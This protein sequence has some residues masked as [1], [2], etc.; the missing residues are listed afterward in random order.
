MPAVFRPPRF[1]LR[2]FLFALVLFLHETSAK[3]PLLLTDNSSLSSHFITELRKE[4]RTCVRL[5]ESDAFYLLELAD[6]LQKTEQRDA[7][8]GLTT[9]CARRVS[10]AELWTDD[11]LL[12]RQLPV[13]PN[14]AVLAEKICE[15]IEIGRASCRERV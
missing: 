4:L 14:P 5:T 13:S 6:T 8:R 1:F 15:S 10:F 3:P 7:S 2:F 12:T 9:R 11:G